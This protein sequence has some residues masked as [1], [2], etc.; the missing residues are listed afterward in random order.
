MRTTRPPLL[1]DLDAQPIDA[2]SCRFEGS[3]ART[4]SSYSEMELGLDLGG[5]GE[6]RSDAQEQW[7]QGTFSASRAPASQ[8]SQNLS[9]QL[10]Q[11]EILSYIRGFE[12]GVCQ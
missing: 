8:L 7:S 4:S 9:H 10:V 12:H 5:V 6:R 2:W 3:S 1:I 11:R